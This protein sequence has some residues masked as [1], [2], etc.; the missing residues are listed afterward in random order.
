MK[1][2]KRLVLAAGVLA[3]HL[4]AGAH[5]GHGDVAAVHGNDFGAWLMHQFYDG[6]LL[7]LAALGTLVALA[8][9]TLSARR[10]AT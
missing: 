4:T 5:P 6:H 10:R 3:T 1:S 7:A 8:A 9:K 2:F